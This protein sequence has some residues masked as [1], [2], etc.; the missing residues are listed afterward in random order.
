MSDANEIEV[1]Y[2]RHLGTDIE[3]DNPRRFA[4]QG[5]SRKHRRIKTL[6]QGL[7]EQFGMKT[8]Q[9]MCRSFHLGRESD[10][11]QNAQNLTKKS[12]LMLYSTT[13]IT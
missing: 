9:S 3:N 13:P 1:G 8:V 5:R 10:L 11:V 2:E 4:S 7:D 12:A 6:M